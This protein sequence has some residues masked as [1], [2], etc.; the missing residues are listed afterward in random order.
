MESARP[1]LK[2]TLAVAMAR[3]G[4][5]VKNDRQGMTFYNTNN[6]YS[7]VTQW[8]ILTHSYPHSTEAQLT[9]KAESHQNVSKVECMAYHFC[10][11]SVM[12][13][14]KDITFVELNEHPSW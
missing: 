5:E 8:S 1:Q 7:S 4:N 2:V 14:Q 6:T 11:D 9:E 10:E 3:M 13:I 12:G